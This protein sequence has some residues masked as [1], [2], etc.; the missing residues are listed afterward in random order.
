L[1]GKSPTNQRTFYLNNGL[2]KS[3]REDTVREKIQIKAHSLPNVLQETD[4][5]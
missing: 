5:L 2:A 3:S 1:S 4:H